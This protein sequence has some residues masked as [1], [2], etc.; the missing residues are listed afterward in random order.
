MPSSRAALVRRADDNGIFGGVES[1][2]GIDHLARRFRH[3][4]FADI[5]KRGLEVGSTL[6]FARTAPS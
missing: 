2:K 5:C 6:V 1:V 4:G 3:F